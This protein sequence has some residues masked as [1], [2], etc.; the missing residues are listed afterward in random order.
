M[1]AFTPILFFAYSEKQG[2]FVTFFVFERLWSS[3]FLF[4]C[5]EYLMTLGV[6]IT[7]VVNKANR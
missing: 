3:L 4:L 6:M 7:D 1:A 2:N 5:E